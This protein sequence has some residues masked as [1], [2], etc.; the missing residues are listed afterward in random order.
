MLWAQAICTTPNK[1]VG[2]SV[3]A[4]P[5]LR[6]AVNG[7]V[8]LGFP[9][10]TDDSPEAAAELLQDEAL[11]NGRRLVGELRLF[12]LLQQTVTRRF[13]HFLRDESVRQPGSYLNDKLTQLHFPTLNTVVLCR[14]FNLLTVTK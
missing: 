11:G 7:T 5:G 13:G 10:E 8:R 1:Q 9:G 2:L 6:L 12:G 3:T 14:L 4:S